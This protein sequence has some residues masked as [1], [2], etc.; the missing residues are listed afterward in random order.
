MGNYLSVNEVSIFMHLL[1]Q[2]A[3]ALFY[4]RLRNDDLLFYC[5]RSELERLSFMIKIDIYDGYSIPF[6]ILY[7]S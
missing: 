6:L 4:V 7:Q 5:I 1:R 2:E 3:K